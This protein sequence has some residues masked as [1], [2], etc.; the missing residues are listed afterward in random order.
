[1]CVFNL[2]EPPNS[3]SE[4]VKHLKGVLKR[5]LNGESPTRMPLEGVAEYVCEEPMIRD[6]NTFIFDMDLLR[7]S[8]SAPI[9]RGWHSR[10]SD[11]IWAAKCSIAFGKTLL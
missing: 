2:V 6:G 7:V 1:M 10:R 9:F 5:I 8:N 4:A 3:A 11:M